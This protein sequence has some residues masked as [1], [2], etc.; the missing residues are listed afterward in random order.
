M[1]IQ[2]CDISHMG[3]LHILMTAK[4]NCDYLIVGD[5]LDELINSASL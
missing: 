1:L 5:I 2:A 3:N 4:K